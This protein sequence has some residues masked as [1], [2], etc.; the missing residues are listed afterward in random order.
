MSL[1]QGVWD[2]KSG[3][4]EDDGDMEGITDRLAG[5]SVGNKSNINASPGPSRSPGR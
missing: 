5:S 2:G 3:R 1:I 4:I